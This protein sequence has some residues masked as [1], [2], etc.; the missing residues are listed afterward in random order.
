MIVLRLSLK[1][2]DYSTVKISQLSRLV[3]CQDYSTVKIT[4]LSR[5]LN[6]QDYSTVKITQLSRLLN[7]Q[8]YSTV[9]ISQLSR[10]VNC[11]DYSTV[12]K[13][14]AFMEH[15]PQPTTW[16]YPE[17]VQPTPSQSVFAHLRLS[18]LHGLLF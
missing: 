5:L 10:L 8:D 12:K 1:V 15:T 2:D 14:P 3:N 7:C 13:F 11:Q 18:L 17:E 4:Q 9:K 6:C 16:P